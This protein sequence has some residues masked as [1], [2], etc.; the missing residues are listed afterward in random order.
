MELSSVGADPVETL[1][2]VMTRA[3]K[4]EIDPTIRHAAASH[5]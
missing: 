2:D 1:D 4:E 5:V 3:L